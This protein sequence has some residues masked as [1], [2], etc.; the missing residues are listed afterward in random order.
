MHKNRIIHRDLKPENLIFRHQNDY[1]SIVIADYGL[2]TKE[3]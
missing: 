3:D 1:K 2:A